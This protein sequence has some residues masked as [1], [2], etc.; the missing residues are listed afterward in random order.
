MQPDGSLFSGRD[1]CPILKEL[2]DSGAA[3]VGFNCVPLSDLTPG[4]VSKLRRHVKGPLICKPNA[5]E[6]FLDEDGIAQ[7][8]ME[9]EDFGNLLREC[10]LSGASLVGGC[11]G[12]TPRHIAAAA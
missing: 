11:C 8:P 3:A 5:G 2:E 7:Y 9:A 12:T 6:P 4:L 1:A 10:F